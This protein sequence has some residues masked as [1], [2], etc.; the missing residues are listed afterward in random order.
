M[1]SLGSDPAL[2]ILL[3][4]LTSLSS[5]SLLLLFPAAAA[6][7]LLGIWRL[8]AWLEACNSVAA[9]VKADRAEAESDRGKEGTPLARL[10]SLP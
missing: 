8:S 7:T 5:A 10:F 1:S 4:L 2:A 6:S 9:R 3:L